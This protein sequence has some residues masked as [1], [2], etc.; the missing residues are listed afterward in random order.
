MKLPQQQLTYAGVAIVAATYGLARYSYGLF[1][2]DIRVALG[3]SPATLGFIA[4]G[5]YVG[6]LLATAV[7]SAVASRTGP[8]LL[9]LVGG[10]C[11]CLGMGLVALAPSGWVLAVGVL[12]AGTGSGWVYPAMP[13]AVAQKVPEREQDRALSWI[14]A[15]T[16]FGVLLSGPVA[17]LL[18][19]SWRTAWLCFAVFT[20]LVTVWN[21]WVLPARP[22]EAVSVPKLRLSW[23]MC[24]RSGPLFAAAFGLGF[25]ASV[26][27]TFAVDLLVSV[28]QLP[29]SVGQLFWV[30]VGA[31]GMV[32]VAA[33]DLIARFGMRTFFI[34]TGVVIALATALLGLNPSSIVPAFIS[35]ALFGAGFFL[36][37]G[38]MAVWSV[39]VFRSRP[40]T[41]LGA[42]FLLIAAGQLVGPPV[43]GALVPTLGMPLLFGLSALLML[44]VL[45]FQPREVGRAVS[46]EA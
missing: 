9:V 11:A 23:F 46:S 33:G 39:A 25:V 6:Y 42:T 10:L 8:R 32:G 2:P 35:A 21:L 36:I 17:L 26:Y 34:A 5:S 7:S 15:G 40:S 12:L 45:V 29:P 28:G 44:G 22:A 43:F 31:A 18:S 3:L 13:E 38:L 41:G 24:P 14:N 30:L 19:G 4:S 37:T 27:W 1:L 16:S 20:L